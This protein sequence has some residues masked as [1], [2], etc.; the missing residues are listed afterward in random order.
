MVDQLNMMK[1]IREETFEV[2]EEMVKGGPEALRAQL[3]RAD[4][5]QHCQV[6]SRSEIEPGTVFE[7]DEC[8]YSMKMAGGL[9]VRGLS[10]QDVSHAGGQW[11]IPM[12]SKDEGELEQATK[13]A[14]NMIRALGLTPKVVRFGSGWSVLE[15]ITGKAA[16]VAVV[17][18]RSAVA[19][20]CLACMC[21]CAASATAIACSTARCAAVHRAAVAVAA[22][23]AAAAA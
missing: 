13:E 9:G 19:A 16:A 8:E 14:L 6:N 10:V 4:H 7:M 15:E 21:R 22:A 3:R 17:A 1:T 18:I 11:L 2:M 12:D 23:L 5:A 20:A